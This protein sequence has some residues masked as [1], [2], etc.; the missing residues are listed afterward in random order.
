MTA[1][2]WAPLTEKGEIVVAVAAV[3]H[4]I[5]QFEKRLKSALFHKCTANPLPDEAVEMIFRLLTFT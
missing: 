1:A 2:A 4:D 3:L 5:V